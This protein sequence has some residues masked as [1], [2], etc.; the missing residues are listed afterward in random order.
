MKPVNPIA[1]ALCLGLTAAIVA[2][3][4]ARATVMISSN[5]V[6]SYANDGTT[7]SA[8][9]NNNT[10]I[11]KSDSAMITVGAVSS[12]TD[13]VYSAAGPLT[14]LSYTLNQS[15]SGDTGTVAESYNSSLVFSVDVLSTYTLS[16]SY[17]V[18]DPGWTANNPIP[19]GSVYL[20]SVL[21]ETAI[22]GST[23]SVSEQ[24]SLSTPNESFALGG[25]GGDDANDFQGSLT[26]LL[27]PGVDYYWFWIASIDQTTVGDGGA[28][29]T[30]DL[31]L[32]IQEGNT[33]KSDPNTIPEPTTLALF[34]VGLAG[35][36]V[37]RRKSKRG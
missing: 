18:T 37:V 21:G 34:G 15:R 7:S 22:G 31:T 25:T 1:A 11:P 26:G 27:L 24:Y 14:T 8:F 23:L 6:G 3:T 13:F 20:D 29:A 35:L 30:G 5:T 19:V 17:T 12:E 36:G 32:T 28:E 2:P 4:H 9:E 33:I 16:G 10:V